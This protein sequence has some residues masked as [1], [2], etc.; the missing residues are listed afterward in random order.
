MLL[1][2]AVY[3]SIAICR[4]ESKDLLI[5]FKQNKIDSFWLRSKN[6]LSKIQSYTN[7]SSP[8]IMEKIAVCQKSFYSG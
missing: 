3:K 5:D 2:V 8:D 4:E 6:Y 7:N 1:E